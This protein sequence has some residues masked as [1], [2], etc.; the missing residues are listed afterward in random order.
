VCDE[1]QR[2]HADSALHSRAQDLLYT[3]HCGA[4]TA[5][6]GQV[7]RSQAEGVGLGFGVWDLGS[8]VWGLEFGVWDLGLGVQDLGFT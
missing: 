5:R 4:A 3:L 2:N 6:V 1:H 7:F 8:G